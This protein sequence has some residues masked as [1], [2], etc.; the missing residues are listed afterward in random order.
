LPETSSAEAFILANIAGHC[1]KTDEAINAISKAPKGKEYIDFHFLDFMMGLN[2]LQRLDED[3]D[4]YLLS[5]VNN[6]KGR[7]YIKEAYQKL[8]W[9]ALV[10][11]DDED[12]AKDYYKKCIE[13]GYKLLDEDISAHKEALQNKLADPLVLKSR[14]LFDGGFFEKS[15]KLIEGNKKYFTGNYPLEYYY[16]LGRNYQMSKRYAEALNSYQNLLQLKEAKNTY[17]QC[18]A[19]LQSG[20]IYEDLGNYSLAHKYFYIAL[21]LSPDKYKRSLHQKSKAGL[22]RLKGKG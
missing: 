7:N 17:Q 15:I 8:A 2:K 10:I 6:F 19:A 16:R 21:K 5:F 12:L 20:I 22:N 13:R 14:L 9:H 18:N 1:G 3:A 11:N 4:Q